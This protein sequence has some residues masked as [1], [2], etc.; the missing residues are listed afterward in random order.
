[1]IIFNYIN[2]GIVVIV[3]SK[4]YRFQISLEKVIY[5][6]DPVKICFLEKP[7]LWKGTFP[8]QLWSLI[9][10]WRWHSWMY[11]TFVSHVGIACVQG[12]VLYDLRVR[13]EFSKDLCFPNRIPKYLFNIKI[14]WRWF[15][16]HLWQKGFIHILKKFL[17]SFSSNDSFSFVWKENKRV[18]LSFFILT[19][20]IL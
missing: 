2:I 16:I 10:K 20:S 7:S 15:P 4:L 19:G 12:R 11:D 9:C 13:V 1:M 17:F 18:R 8:F 3:L 5:K 6:I 14:N